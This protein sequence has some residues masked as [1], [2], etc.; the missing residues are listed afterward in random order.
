[1]SS[2]TVPGAVVTGAGSAIRRSCLGAGQQLYIVRTAS[3]QNTYTHTEAINYLVLAQETHLGYR[4]KPTAVWAVH[5]ACVN[6]HCV[7]LVTGSPGVLLSCTHQIA[8]TAATQRRRGWMDRTLDPPSF[9][10]Y[11][12]SRS[13]STF[14]AGGEYAIS[15]NSSHV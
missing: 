13:L 6:K 10:I 14:Y 2:L 15:I 9:V 7:A 5:K 11:F 8:N 1:M 3:T 12:V 4:G